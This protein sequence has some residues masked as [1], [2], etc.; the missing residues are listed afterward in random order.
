MGL[1]VEG[2]QFVTVSEDGLVIQLS[3]FVGDPEMGGILMF[4]WS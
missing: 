2:S 1:A 3:L 4:W